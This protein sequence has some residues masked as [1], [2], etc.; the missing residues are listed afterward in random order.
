MGES[1]TSTW[2]GNGRSHRLKCWVFRLWSPTLQFYV[3]KRPPTFRE[4]WTGEVVWAPNPTD[5]R[6]PAAGE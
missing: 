5:P 6:A 4:A 1:I 3:G 2:G